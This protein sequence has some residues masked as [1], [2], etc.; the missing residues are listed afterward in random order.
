MA[1]KDREGQQVKADRKVVIQRAKRLANPPEVERVWTPDRNAMLAA[2][3]VVLGL[4]KTPPR[5]LE[6]LRR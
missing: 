3:R 2:L 6:E 5:W 1:A 4:P